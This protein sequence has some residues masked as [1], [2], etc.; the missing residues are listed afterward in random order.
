VIELLRC[1]ID[2]RDV[3]VVCTERGDGDVHPLKVPLG[4]LRERQRTATGRTWAMLDQVHGADRVD[5][6]AGE[7]SG[8]GSVIGVGDVLVADAGQPVAIW[9][10]DCA[11]LVLIGAHGVIV[12]CH[13]G[14]RGLAAG[15]IDVAVAAVH[16][17]GGTRRAV[18][19]P[20]IHP[21][22][23]EFGAAELARVADGLDV[24]PELITA[25]TRS[26][27]PALDVPAAVA[28]AVGRHGIVLDVVGPCTGCDE[29]WFS[30]RRGDLGRHAVVAWGET[31]A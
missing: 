8:T 3:T 23:Y 10:A 9:A 19:G 14:W 27:A 22:C 24:A 17:P 25:T 26:G 7:S 20:C 29:R 15:V 28:L 16:G 18:L 4:D 21:C 11:S 13:A 30:H 5:L 2:G 1:P 31:A 12:G 6:G